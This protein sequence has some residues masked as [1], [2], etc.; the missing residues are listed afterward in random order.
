MWT[1]IEAEWTAI[2][3]RAQADLVPALNAL[4]WAAKDAAAEMAGLVAVLRIW[5]RYHTNRKRR[6]AIKRWI[7][8]EAAMPKST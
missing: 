2:L 6:N 8:R 1:D 3:D 5:S 7:R 4:A